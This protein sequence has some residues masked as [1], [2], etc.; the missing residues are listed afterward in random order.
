MTVLATALAPLC[1]FQQFIVYRAVP[2]KTRPGKIDKF[3]IN[4][5][6]GDISDA[7]DSTNWTDYSMATTAAALFGPGYGVGFALTA[8]D[9]FFCLD[10]DACLMPDGNWSPFAI[11]MVSRF[12]DAATEVSISGK[13]LH[14][15]GR[16]S[17]PAMPHSCKNLENNAELYTE[18][19]FIAL[20]RQEDARG[21]V[22]AECTDALNPVI[23]EYFP[24][25]ISPFVNTEAWRDGG[26]DPAEDLALIERML[27]SKPS[28]NA[29]FG[30]G[31]TFAELWN[32][33]PEALGKAY[34]DKGGNRP[35]DESSADFALALRLAFWTEKDHARIERLMTQSKLNRDK[36]NRSDYLHRT[37]SKAV[38]RQNETRMQSY[39]CARNAIGL[40]SVGGAG[41]SVDNTL[42]QPD[43]L[44]A[45]LPP[46]TPYPVK[47]LGDILG[48][49]AM[50]LHESVKAPLAL[51]CQS[52]LASASLAAQAHFDIEL[53]WGEKKPL[54]LFLLTVAESGERKSG[55]DDC[56][57]GAAKFQEKLD[58]ERYHDE[59]EQYENDLARWKSANEQ[60]NKKAAKAK[61]SVPTPSYLPEAALQGT[62][63]PE[64]PI[65]PLR[66]ISDP[67][68]EGLFKLLLIG[69]PSVGLFS[70]EA[71]LLIGGH[72]L[73]NDNALKTLARWCKLWDGSP[74]DRVRAGDGSGC[75]YGRR[76]AMHQL[77]QP[78]VMAKLLADRMANGQGFLARCLVAWP[79]STI[80]SRH[81][82][83]FEWPG[84]RNELK[85]LFAVLKGLIEATPRTAKSAQELYPLDL[86]LD[87]EAK[88]LAITASNQFETSMQNGNDLS[89]LKDRTAKAM[90][91][92]CRI[93]GV[94]AVIEGGM[95][96]RSI[97]GEHL[98]RGLILIRW[99]LSEALRIRSAAII[100]QAVSDA[101]LLSRWLQDRNMTGFRTTPV[102]THGPSQLRNKSRLMAA[103]AELVNHGYLAVNEPGSIVD[104][105]KARSS[106]RV[107]HYVL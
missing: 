30:D 82:N 105:V 16:Y 73:N 89:E 52:V 80:G 44:R 58:M 93:A 35:Y 34:P 41:R 63:K 81:I 37:I 86:P 53:P 23:T 59:L 18:R 36:W 55:I 51:C 21:N 76:M 87:H 57:L 84:D 19:R 71:G 40:V 48:S 47:A 107:L 88:Q 96:T 29:M 78:D 60:Q 56:V 62:S 38:A 32:G 31:V 70:D 5:R 72:A 103:I 61:N 33:D 99:Y 77:A 106:W 69:Q 91:N 85:R 75:L 104:S 17:G 26:A 22:G 102:L 25:S 45:P 92:A 43:P 54:S 74:F 49:A 28:I 42:M 79:E 7:H 11:Q 6:N 94:M 97:T 68:V 50:A 95:G 100:P 12:P 1:E 83:D 39:E 2:S 9:P 65:M 20:G 46:S 3:P 66:F 98:E 27:K 64:A 8:N 24:V 15:W 13:G 67:T 90:E 101:E 4:Y 10:L 14:I